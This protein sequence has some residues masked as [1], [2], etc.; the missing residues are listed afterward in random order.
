[1]KRLMV[2]LCVLILVCAITERARADSFVL[3]V[4]SG[5][6]WLDVAQTP[7]GNLCWAA[8]ASNML[9]YS[10]WNGGFISPADI[11]GEFSSHWSNEFGN[12]YYGINWWF[13]GTGEGSPAHVTTAGGGYYS[14]TLFA[15]NNGYDEPG[16]MNPDNFNASVWSYVTGNVAANRVFSMDLGDSGGGIH[17]LTGWGY[18]NTADAHKVWVTDSWTGATAGFWMNLTWDGSHWV[19]DYASSSCNGGQGGDCGWYVRAMD[20][21][22]INSPIVPPNGGGNGTVPEPTSTLL[23]LGIGLFGLSVGYRK[24]R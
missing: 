5:G 19:S 12:P 14:G 24:R 11:F 15:A 16:Y 7:Y 6:G 18:D 1:M 22:Q 8:S 10:G 9:A 3:N 2:L 17:W 20:S 23:L 13:D 21:L 4:T